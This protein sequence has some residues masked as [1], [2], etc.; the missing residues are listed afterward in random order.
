MIVSGK[1]VRK[2]S[3]WHK[4]AAAA[5]WLLLCCHST[6]LFAQSFALKTNLLYDAT[7]TPSLGFELPMSTKHWTYGVNGGFRPWPTDDEVT[8]KYRHVLVSPYVRLW[9]DSIYRKSFFSLYA[10]YSHYNVADVKFPFGLYKEVRDSRRQGD[11]GALGLSY[12]Y[13][14]PLSAR[15]HL[16]A[17][18]GMALAFTR[19]EE[20]ACGH[21]GAK[22]G[23][24][25]KLFALPKVALN[26]VYNIGPKPKPVEEEPEVIELAPVEADT[27]QATDEQLFVFEPRLSVVPDFRGRAG[28][29]QQ[30]NPVLAH[31]SE[32]RPYDRTRIM[33][34]EKDA[35]YVHFP[36]SKYELREDF[37]DNGPVLQRILDITRQIMADSTSSVKRIQIIGLASIEGAVPAN[38]LLA[39]N[40]AL[41][42]QRYIQRQVP[43]PDSLYETVGGGEA[44][45]DFRDQLN[46]MVMADTARAAVT[47]QLRQALDIVDNEPDVNARERK[48]KR[49]N[50]GRTWQYI[51]Q[52]V[53]RDQRNSGY[54]R[55]Y[56]DYVPD[57]AAA[58]INLASELLAERR[59]DEALALLRS[60]GSDERALN[61]LG[62]ALWQT[63]Q[64]EEALRCFRRAAESGNIDARENLRQLEN[65][66]V[67]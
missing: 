67:K 12:G 30:D 46:D 29:L 5:L 40:R 26:L 41:A 10:V 31:V 24:K 15:W 63:G 7:L 32:Y 53:L 54:M 28:I 2:L 60:V 35:L 59:Y 57:K 36:L 21:C 34:K 11:L 65:Q 6:A 8:R 66:P 55:I 20:F 62:V 37:R 42:L 48:L 58:D 51:K 49:M 17:E 47:A 16:E 13:N 64:K 22:L 9:T 3:R 44:W 25:N 38:E 52:H 18:A 45:A 23:T 33:R 39:R 50:G 43:T 4:A 1:K 27:L 61:A 19:F 56:Y 14:W